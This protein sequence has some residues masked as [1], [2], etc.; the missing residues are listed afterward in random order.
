MRAPVLV[1]VLGIA[2]LFARTAGADPITI[3]GIGTLNDAVAC[4]TPRFRRCVQQ[5]LGFTAGRGDS[6]TFSL[7]YHSASADGLLTLPNLWGVVPRLPTRTH[8]STAV[9]ASP[10]A[11]NVT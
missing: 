4:G 2:L 9:T 3:S 5:L 11:L 7:S 6:F 10:S 1:L 8:S